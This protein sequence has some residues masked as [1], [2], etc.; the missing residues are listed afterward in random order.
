MDEAVVLGLDAG[1][2]T[3]RLALATRDGRV[4]SARTA[5]GS[6][7]FDQPNWRAIL[8]GLFEGLA[9][10]TAAVAGLAGYGE[11]AEI[12]TAQEVTMAALLPQ[13]HSLH[14][15]VQ[16]A[17]DGAFL[18]GCGVLI[19][20]GTGS[21]AWTRRDDASPVRVGG[22]GHGIGDEG[23][24][25]WIGL[26]ALSLTTQALDGRLEAP[27]FA[28]A[29]LG[30][31]GGGDQAGLIGWYHARTHPR[32]EVAAL[33]RIVDDLAARGDAVA[34]TL[35]KDAAGQ[36]YAHVAAARRLTG[37]AC[38]AWSHA[39]GLFASA[40]LRQAMIDRLGRPTAPALPPLGGALWRAA[41]LA[42]WSPDLAWVQRLSHSLATIETH[43][44]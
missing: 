19:L 14:N 31:I 35:I 41:G 26:R 33:A 7:P 9:R 1:G 43:A 13:A 18:G 39:G 40:A 15:D 17:F 36:L 32:S 24:A 30:A 27:A 29:I 44:P 34:T 37:R 23:S 10:P 6:N 42:G 20:A 12:S 2:S 21:M 22:W 5:D 16:V 25:H 28:A 38:D 8:A 3:T 4:V 11:V